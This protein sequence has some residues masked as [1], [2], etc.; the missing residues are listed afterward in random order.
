[1]WDES[2]T[3]EKAEIT[4]IS[5][6]ARKKVDPEAEATARVK[7]KAIA[8]KRVAAESGADTRV[9]VEAK[10]EVRDRYVG[11]L[12][13]ILNKVKAISNGLKRAMVVSEEDTKEKSERSKADV[14]A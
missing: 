12:A 10:A 11:I 13:V 9:R 1:M 5:A 6:K 3:M 4:R 8:T 2:K 7:E 14:E